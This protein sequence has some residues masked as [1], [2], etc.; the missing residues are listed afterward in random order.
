[1]TLRTDR[2]DVRAAS[3]DLKFD[4]GG[5][6]EDFESYYPTAGLPWVTRASFG[7]VGDVER[8]YIMSNPEH[9]ILFKEDQEII[10]HMIWHESNTEEHSGGRVRAEDDRTVLREL[11]GQG[12]EFAELHEL[13]LVRSRRGRGYGRM[14]FDFF[15][16]FARQRS[17]R[18]VVHYAFDPA[19][20]AICHDRGYR[21][22]F[23]VMSG[24]EKS[25]VLCLD[26]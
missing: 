6:L 12:E 23:G 18:H 19:A 22:R 16:K 7:R 4:V 24:G 26:L 13:W 20:L 3:R 8:S 17:F 15:E 2:T 21:D 1:M 5:N 10:G 25:H 9:L 14:F 11:L